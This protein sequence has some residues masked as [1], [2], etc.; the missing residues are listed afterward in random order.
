LTRLPKPMPPATRPLVT[1]GI[2]YWLRTGKVNP[3]IKGYR[4][5][6]RY[7]ADLERRLVEDSGGEANLTA[8]REILIRTTIRAY[9]VIA[10]A[11]LYAGRFS[12]VR[13]DQAKY[14]V[15]TFQPILE[16]A[17]S[18]FLSQ[19]RANLALLGLDRRSAEATPLEAILA[20]YA[21]G[22][23]LAGPAAPLEAHESGQDAPATPHGEPEG[24]EGE[25]T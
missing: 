25:P 5:V 8:Q 21:P 15:L 17:Y 7:L 6:Q 22:G 13:P 18:S 12:V 10:L 9:G 19:I 2:E 20:D 14:G 16:R 11:E 24:G 23:R 4:K 3:S 1:H